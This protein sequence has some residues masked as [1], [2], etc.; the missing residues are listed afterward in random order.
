MKTALIEIVNKLL[1]KNAD[2][3]AQRLLQTAALQQLIN[4]TVDHKLIFGAVLC[5]DKN[6]ERFVGSAG[7]FTPHQPFFIASTTKLYIT[8]LILMLQEQGKL[9]LTHPI[10]RYLPPAVIQ[11]LHVLN[12]QDYSGVI[13]IEQLLAHTSGLPDYFEDAA[14]GKRSMLQEIASG[15]DCQWTF[16]DAI[17]L[18]KQ[19]KP[20]FT[21]N[22]P[23]KAHYSDTNYQ[24][25]GKIIELI[26]DKPLQTVLQQMIAEPLCLTQTYLYTDAANT[27]VPD[28]YYKNKPLHIPQAMTGFGADGGMVATA[29]ELVIFLKAFFGGALFPQQALPPLCQTW[30]AVMYPLEYGVGIMRFKPPWYFSPL[31]ALP[32]FLGHSGL[33]GAFAFY[34]PQTN[35]YIAGTVNQIARPDTAFRLMIKAITAA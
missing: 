5:V 2:R 23:H 35:T 10:N 18:A 16:D 17:A 27:A 24:L 34:A 11:N 25:L 14:P 15:K 4:Q 31:Y 30:N 7:N 3:K 12:G 19:M 13:T 26:E 22:Q 1:Q 20:K 6:G 33:S 32:E 9:Q 29:E 28:I 21:P 8:A